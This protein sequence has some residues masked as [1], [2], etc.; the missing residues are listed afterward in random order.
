MLAHTT[1]PNAMVDRITSRPR[2]TWPRRCE[3]SHGLGR[4]GS[5]LWVRSCIQ[6]VIETDFIAGRPRGDGRCRDGAVGAGAMKKPR[7]DLLNATH[8]C[9]AWGRHAGGLPAYPRRHARRR[10]SPD[11]LRLR[12]PTMRSPVLHTPEQP[13]PIDLEAYRDVVLDRFGNPAICQ[14]AN[15]RVAM[16][17][18]SKIPGMIAPTIRDKLARQRSFDS[19]AT[20]ACAVPARTCSAGTRGRSPHLPGDQA[21]GLPWRMPYAAPA[22]PVTAYA[23]DATLWA[24]MASHPKLVDAC[25]KPMPACRHLWQAGPTPDAGVISAHCPLPRHDH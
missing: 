8:S 21:M 18:F 5:T 3:G 13:C 2:P 10:H 9:I 4:Q 19:V 24:E 25:A 16:D 6:W 17:A 11:G 23:A 14:T 12:P 1:S 22:D 7:S 15:Q 20:A